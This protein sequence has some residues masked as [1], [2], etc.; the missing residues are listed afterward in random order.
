MCPVHGELNDTFAWPPATAMY[1]LRNVAE[2]RVGAI[3]V[4]AARGRYKTL[5]NF[6]TSA[7]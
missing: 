7:A 5:S 2:G 6:V 3:A 4:C 1:L